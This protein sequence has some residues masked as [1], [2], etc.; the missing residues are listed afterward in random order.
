MS[1]PRKD[2]IEQA[3][4]LLLKKEK[5]VK[6]TS[7]AMRH[8]ILQAQNRAAYMN[9]YDRIQ[10][11]V[12]GYADRFAGK[13]NIQQLKNKQSDL[14]RLFR[15]SHEHHHPIQGNPIA[16]KTSVSSKTSL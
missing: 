11:I 13:H 6:P 1:L 15:E 9:E 2:S 14:R 10:G 5:V 7:V 3:Y 16:R 12:S 4:K 8:Q